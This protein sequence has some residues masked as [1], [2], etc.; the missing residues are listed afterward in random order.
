MLYQLSYRAGFCCS[1]VEGRRVYYIDPMESFLLAFVP[2][3]VAIDPIGLI[4]LF[5]GVTEGFDYAEKK[6]LAIQSVFTA[7]IVGFI[8][9]VAGH[10]IFAF[11][12]ISPADFKIAG[13]V[14]LLIFSVREIYG[15]SAKLTQGNVHDAFIGIV[16][17]GIPMIVG[18]AVITTIL[19]LHDLHSLITIMLALAANLIIT[20]GLFVY[21]DA[22]VKRTG[23]AFGKVVAKVVAIFLAAIGIMMIRKGVESFLGNN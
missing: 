12:G 5:M 15:N 2:L 1:Y 3:F 17:L 23:E 6:R 13:G 10:Y 7:F 14:L 16:P 20:L 9:G 22:I 21:S 8:F 11:L 4:P 19:I 18:P